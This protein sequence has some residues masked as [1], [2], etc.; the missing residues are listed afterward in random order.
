MNFKGRVDL[1]DLQNFLRISDKYIEYTNLL[2]GVF[3]S[4]CCAVTEN[5]INCVEYDVFFV[6]FMV[7]IIK[8]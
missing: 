2:N 4:S 6:N 3:E 1:F 5:L 8:N 7:N